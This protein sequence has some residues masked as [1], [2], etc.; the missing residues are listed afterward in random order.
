MKNIL[1]VILPLL[2]ALLFPADTV[3][4]GAVVLSEPERDVIVRTNDNDTLRISLV[5]CWPGPEIYE[6]AGH[7][8]IRITGPSFD[9]VWNY[10]IFDFNEPNFVGRFV[11]GKTDYKVVAYPFRW[12]L[13]E[14]ISRGS[15]VEEQELL[16]TAEEKL[17]LLQALRENALPENATYRYN[18]VRNNCATRIVDMVDSAST[19]RIIYPDTLHYGTFRAAMRAYHRN[20]PWYQ[21]GIDLVLGSGLDRPITRRQEMFIPVEMNKVFASARFA[22]NRGA[23]VGKRIVLNEGR[24]D[25]ILPPTPWYLTPLAASILMAMLTIA[26]IFVWKI[27]KRLWRWWL[28]TYF[29]LC[30]LAGIVVTYLVFFSSHEATSPNLLILWLN[31]LQLIIGIGIWF[32]SMRWPAVAIAGIDVITLSLLLIVRGTHAQISNPAILIMILSGIGLAALYAIIG[33]SES[34]YNIIGSTPDPSR[35]PSRQGA[36]SL[37]A[38]RATHSRKKGGATKRERH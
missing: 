27:Q 13:P 7:E 28:S 38:R 30:G 29:I 24:S 37:S 14:Y 23:V 8:A 2:L 9:Q 1:Y 26:T 19:R 35:S 17:R 6:L 36:G 10:G 22:G 20:Y 33:A 15:R 32:R 21:F 4:E 16:L 31:P 25:A 12:F 3:A 18:Y 34:Y 11:A 5:T